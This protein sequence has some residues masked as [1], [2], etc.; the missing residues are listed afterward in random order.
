MS[1]IYSFLNVRFSFSDTFS[2]LTLSGQGPYLKGKGSVVNQSGRVSE[3]KKKN[4]NKRSYFIFP[5]KDN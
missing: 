3:I 4:S 2:P 1:V 5:K